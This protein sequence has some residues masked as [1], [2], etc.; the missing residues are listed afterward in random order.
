MGNKRM[1]QK[2]DV[3]SENLVL[4]YCQWRK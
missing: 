3:G 4:L 1:Q 2:S